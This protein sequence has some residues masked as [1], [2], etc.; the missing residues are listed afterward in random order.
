MIIQKQKY[1]AIYM[2]KT[3]DIGPVYEMAG[4]KKRDTGLPVNLWIDDMGTYIKGRHA[5]RIK[6]QAN[7]GNSQGG[8]PTIPMMLNGEIP[9]PAFSSIRNS[10]LSSSDIEEIKN[11]VL[12]NSEALSVLADGYISFSEFISLMIKNGEEATDQEITDQ[13]DKLAFLLNE[14]FKRNHSE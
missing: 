12:N 9:K 1:K 4:L 6:F 2:K 11:F 5:K 10:E 3:N 7:K 8:Q 14:E 13:A